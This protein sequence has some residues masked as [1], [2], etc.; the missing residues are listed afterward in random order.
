MRKIMLAAAIALLLG[1]VSCTKTHDCK[2]TIVQTLDGMEMGRSEMTYSD[3]K[4]DCSSMNVEQNM[5]AD[6]STMKQTISCKQM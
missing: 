2:C 4:E 3:V 6:G 5:N 1:F